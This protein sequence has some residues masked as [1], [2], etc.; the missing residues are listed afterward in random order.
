MTTNTT[1]TDTKRM[2]CTCAICKLTRNGWG[3]PRKGAGRPTKFKDDRSACV[4]I[5]LPGSLIER[6]DQEAAELSVTR[7]EIVLRRL[8][9]SYQTNSITSASVSIQTLAP[10]DKALSGR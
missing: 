2:V 3:G 9:S 7:S 6:L 4:S 5:S 10:Q 1:Q 8:G